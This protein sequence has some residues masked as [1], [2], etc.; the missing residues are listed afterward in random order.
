[1]ATSCM[2][3]GAALSVLMFSKVGT[4]AFSSVSIPSIPLGST[5]QCAGPPPSV[6]LTR[7]SLQEG[8]N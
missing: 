3:T 8:G 7:S 2:P 5:T 6:P 4:G 1:V